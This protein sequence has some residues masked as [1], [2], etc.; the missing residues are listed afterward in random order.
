M[1]A[2]E[3]F[4]VPLSLYLTPGLA[5]ARVSTPDPIMP[6][7][8]SPFLPIHGLCLYHPRGLGSGGGVAGMAIRIGSWFGGARGGG[9]V[10][11]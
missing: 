8:C 10:I 1:I 6:P 11:Y 7:H 3:A 2:R 4:M 9:V 5:L